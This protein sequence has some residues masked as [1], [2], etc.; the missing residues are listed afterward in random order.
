MS[1][2]K[3]DIYI[4]YSPADS[5]WVHQWL[6]P[7]L[8][9]A[10][11]SVMIDD[12]DFII[13]RTTLANIEG[14]VAACDYTLLVLSSAWLKRE[15][16]DL[17]SFLAQTAEGMGHHSILP[18][19]LEECPLPQR[20][21]I[22]TQLDFRNE[23]KRD[24]QLNRL[25]RQLGKKPLPQSTPPKTPEA[26]ESEG[27]RQPPPKRFLM[28]AVLLLVLIVIGMLQPIATFF[29]GDS[30][31]AKTP[32]MVT[33]NDVPVP[34]RWIPSGQFTMGSPRDEYGRQKD[35]DP[36]R[37]RLS[38]GFWMAETETTQALWVAVMGNNPSTFP[39]ANLPVETVSWHDVQAFLKQ[40]NRLGLGRFRLPTEAEWEYAC[41]AD[42]K[43]T[44][45]LRDDLAWYKD[46]SDGEN[47]PVASKPPNAWGLYDMLGNVWEW[48]SDKYGEYP[49]KKTTDPR[50]ADK[51]SRRV[52]RGG[53]RATPAEDVRAAARSHFFPGNNFNF[54]GFRLVLEAEAQQP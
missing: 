8:E 4:S 25:L 54:L 21:R 13:G 18:L 5:E 15:E 6:V 45:H 23:K 2:H 51:G 47:K 49:D 46:N 53:S 29:E 28:P 31:P 11:L 37:V 3:K 40:L 17:D 41:R 20:L 1:A 42:T 35:E 44:G 10:G 7:R 39:D 27:H 50:G 9:G 12:E 16:A 14:A 38:Q 32:K 19:L 34:F 52:V 22:L 26:S 30:M 24:D 36:Y 33:I 43:Q 48:T